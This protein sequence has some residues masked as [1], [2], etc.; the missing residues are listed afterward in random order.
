[1]SKSFLK[2]LGV[3]VLLYAITFTALHFYKRSIPSANETTEMPSLGPV[4]ADLRA[5]YQSAKSISKEYKWHIKRLWDGGGNILVGR[6]EPPEG[7]KIARILTLQNDGSF[8]TAIYPGRTLELYIHGYE[9]LV[10]TPNEPVWGPICDVGTHTFEKAPPEDLRT[11]TG[12]V[13][14]EPMKG[15]TPEVKLELIVQNE[16]YLGRD[17]GTWQRC[18]RPVVETKDISPGQSFSFEGLSPIP[19]E[20]K[21]SAKGFVT[22]TLTIQ[23]DLRGVID[24][25]AIQLQRAQV[26]RFDYISMIDLDAP[27]TW[28][29]PEDQRVV[30]NNENKFLIATVADRYDS[31]RQ[32]RL[33]VRDGHTYARH[34]RLPSEYYRLGPGKLEDYTKNTN[35]IERTRWSDRRPSDVASDEILLESGYVYFFRNR[36]SDCNC[37]FAVTDI[38]D[39]LD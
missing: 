27:D 34:P 28:P 33:P 30:C 24:L 9:P 16:A 21:I 36:R 2:T 1:M 10:I 37:L 32:F 35:W 17:G 19:Y 23:P 31:K 6:I 15:K 7:A 38:T 5:H 29:S 26:L 20:L 22:Q 3:L 8:A 13:Q 4:M 39:E 18:L 12:S 14:A 25:G 11:L